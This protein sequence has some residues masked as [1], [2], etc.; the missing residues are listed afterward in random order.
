[1]L[2]CNGQMIFGQQFFGQQI[3]LIEENIDFTD[4]IVKIHPYVVVIV[5][6]IFLTIAGYLI[7]LSKKRTGKLIDD[8][9]NIDDVTGYYNYQYFIEKT[10]TMLKYDDVHYAIGYVD[11]SNFKAIND[12]YGREQ[13]NKVLRTVADRINELVLSNGI[14]ARRFADRFVFILGYL[15]IDSLQYIVKTNLSE[16]EYEIDSLK[17]TLKINCNCGLYEVTD[18]KEDVD[19]MVD[20]AAAAAKLAK[21]SISENVMILEKDVSRTIMQNQRITYKMNSAYNNHEFVVYIQPKIGFR[22]GKIVGGEA[23]VRWMSPDEGMISPGAFIPLFER[24][25]FVTKVDFYVLEKVCA[26]I[27][28]RT[29]WKKRNVPISVNQSRLHIYDPMYINKLINTFDRYGVSKSN[30]IFEL[31][32]SA[33]TENTRDMI[34]LMNRMSKLGYKISMDDFGSG[35]S[36]LNM[37]SQL[38]ISELKLDKE[39][40]SDESPKGKYIIKSIVNLAHGLGISTVC[41]GVESEEQVPFL[42]QIGCDIAQG[43]YYAKP[44][45][46]NE[47]EKLLDAGE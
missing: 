4:W 44:M 7:W 31:T 34:D 35:Y 47:F 18:Y 2:L 32:E 39:F 1:M 5:F 36:S 20:K 9:M 23:L 21:G 30:I 46:M 24:N 16:V 19:E 38:P 22:D 14:F 33:F 45:P 27:R 15:D 8:H 6:I 12:F 37:L 10:K 40:L 11:I 25:G 26:M 42:K 13:G 43:F 28:K 3:E 17:E 29:E 41:E